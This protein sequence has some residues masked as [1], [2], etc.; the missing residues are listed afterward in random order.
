MLNPYTLS[1]Y[2]DRKE[3]KKIKSY[4][5]VLTLCHRHIVKKSKDGFSETIYMVPVFVFG[6]PLYDYNL[7]KEYIYNKLTNN[8]LKC[9]YIDNQNILISWRHV[10]NDKKKEKEFDEMLQK[11]GTSGYLL[12]DKNEK[13]ATQKKYREPDDL[14][15]LTINL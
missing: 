15:N 13:E 3:I 14:N 10:E 1:R 12:K 5:Q 6:V 7:C 4:K 11:V 9:R 8:K 2:S